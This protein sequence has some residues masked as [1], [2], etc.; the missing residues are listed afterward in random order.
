M[1]KWLGRIFFKT[2]NE[3]M[4]HTK[5]ELERGLIFRLVKTEHIFMVANVMGGTVAYWRVTKDDHPRKIG[6]MRYMNQ[7]K[8]LK[9]AIER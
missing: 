2:N 1:F 3:I 4:N 5:L 8:F 7:D 9:E 6:K